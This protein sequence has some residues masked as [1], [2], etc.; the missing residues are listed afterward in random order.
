VTRDLNSKDQNT[1]PW[2]SKQ[3]NGRAAPALA[4]GC[5]VLLSIDLTRNYTSFKLS[6]VK[7][8]GQRRQLG[9]GLCMYINSMTKKK[10][11]NMDK[12]A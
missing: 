1:S 6:H 12:G 8:L 10:K 2:A 9:H 4:F 7:L 3:W 11:S 5:R